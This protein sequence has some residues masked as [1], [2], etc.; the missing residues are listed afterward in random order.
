MIKGPKADGTPP[1]PGE[2]WAMDPTWRKDYRRENEVIYALIL[3]EDGNA[4]ADMV[5]PV[6]EPTYLALVDG[7]LLSLHWSWFRSRIK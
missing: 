6:Y 7:E 2:L 4:G 1:R 5:I 3:T